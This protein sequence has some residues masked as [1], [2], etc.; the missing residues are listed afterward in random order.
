V[1]WCRRPGAELEA[2]L[3][4][5]FF[6]EDLDAADRARLVA[7]GLAFVADRPRMRGQVGQFALA[8]RLRRRSRDC[9]CMRR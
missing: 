5:Y 8:P 2:A 4:R 9:R 1:A 6:A 3:A 7:A